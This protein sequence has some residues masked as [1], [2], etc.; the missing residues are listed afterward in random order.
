MNYEFILKD[1]IRNVCIH[2]KLKEMT[3]KNKMMKILKMSWTFLKGIC[4]CTLARRVI[5]I[6]SPRRDKGRSSSLS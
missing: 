4:N 6:N 2:E 1:R 3:S 5:Q